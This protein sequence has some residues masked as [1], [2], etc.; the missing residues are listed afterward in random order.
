MKRNFFF[1]I[2]LFTVNT[3]SIA[4]NIKKAAAPFAVVELFTSEGCSSCPPADKVLSEVIADARKNNKLVYAFS[5][6]VDYWNRLGWKDPYSSFL[7]TSRQNN[8]SDVIGV[9]EVYTPQVFVNGK[10]AF[11]GSDKKRLTTELEKELKLPAKLSLILSKN[12]I[13]T[14]D[15]LFIDYESSKS[16]K[17]YNISLGLVQ[18]GIVSNVG[19]GENSGKTLSHDNVVRVFETLPLNNVKGIIKIPVKKFSLN[20]NF[21]VYG[22]VQQKQTKEILAADGF[23]L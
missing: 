3:I 10:T 19:K 17:N 22:Y 18:R 21:S 5:F 6:H 11:V 9:R 2:F 23:D 15:T 20:S 13:S 7:Y 4:Q 12:S 8:Y 16:D 1:F 14:S